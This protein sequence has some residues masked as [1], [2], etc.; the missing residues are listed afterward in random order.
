MRSSVSNQCVWPTGPKHEASR[1][2]LARH[3]KKQENITFQS[4]TRPDRLASVL[5]VGHLMLGT[6]QIM[7]FARHN[8]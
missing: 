8:P 1:S 4:L 7:S 2:T 3:N 5:I 6:P